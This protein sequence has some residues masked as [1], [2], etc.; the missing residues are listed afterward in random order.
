MVKALRKSINGHGKAV[1]AGLA[2]VASG[3]FILK[4]GAVD[5][6]ARVTNDAGA[7]RR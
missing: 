1:I 4:A 5:W 3:A 2:V 7:T 6:F